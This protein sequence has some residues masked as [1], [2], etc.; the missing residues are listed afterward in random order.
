M[1][2][3]GF[4]RSDGVARPSAD[5]PDDLGLGLATARVVDNTW[6][7]TFA[8]GMTVRFS[9]IVPV[10][11][12]APYLRTCL[13]S[14]VVQT[15]ADFECICVDDGSTDGSGDILDGYAAKDARFRVVHQPNGGEGAA[16]NAGLDVA[17]GEWICFLDADDILR[18]STLKMYDRSIRAHG[19]VDL[20]SVSMLMFPDGHLPV[21][22][23]VQDIQWQVISC[24]RTVPEIAYFRNMFTCAYRAELIAGLR[25][26]KLKIGADRVYFSQVVE[27]LGNVAVC[28]W[29]GYGYRQRA[30]SAFHSRIKAAMLLDEIRHHAILTKTI[31]D[32]RKTYEPAITRRRGLWL[33]ESIADAYYRLPS[34]GRDQ[35]WN[36]W[37]KEMD[38]VSR[39]KGNRPYVWA[40]MRIVVK[41]RS[42]ALARLLIFGILWL[43]L[44]GVNRRLAVHVDGE[45]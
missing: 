19:D 33:V 37:V 40:I 2:V 10:Y 7:E 26:G 31:E 4:A 3:G 38:A 12:V 30:G 29:S 44:H 11:N 17:K 25:F 42:K 14:V 45:V 16:R 1:Q 21:W 22:P 41:T 35:V 9:L 34:S 43:K 5:N 15:F 8:G 39:M 24:E 32:S 23:D 28:D 20:V 27:R 18:E 13:D 36:E 6:G